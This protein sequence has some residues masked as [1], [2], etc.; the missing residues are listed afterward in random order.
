MPSAATQATRRRRSIFRGLMHSFATSPQPIRRA[1][2]RAAQRSPWCAAPDRSPAPEKPD[3]RWNSPDR[4]LS[5]R[6]HGTKRR[7]CDTRRR[8]ATR[9]P[10]RLE[11]YG[12]GG[13]PSAGLRCAPNARFRAMIASICASVSIPPALCAK[14][15]IAV[16]GT[17]FA[18]TF[19]IVRFRPRSPDRRGSARADSGAAFAVRAVASRAVLRIQRF[20]IENVVGLHGNRIRR[21][22]SRQ[23]RAPDNATVRL[24]LRTPRTPHCAPVYHGCASPSGGS[25]ERFSLIAPG[26]S[27]PALNANGIFWRVNTFS[28]RDTTSPATIP[29]P[30]CE[31]T[32]QSQSIFLSSSGFK[33][34]SSCI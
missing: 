6:S 30:N 32:N 14:A 24:R 19:R 15:G 9:C 1:Q 23:A 2:V 7:I 5:H 22:S 8:L 33:I 27:I 4:R 11:A 12:G 3:R 13:D 10:A 31:A 18:V 21:G 16:P 29:N 17:P 26:T 34:P 20:E 28:C 25:P